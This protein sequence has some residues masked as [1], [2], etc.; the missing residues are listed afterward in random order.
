MTI[1]KLQSYTMFRVSKTQNLKPPKPGGHICI[2]CSQCETLWAGGHARVLVPVLPSRLG[3]M[4][5]GA[6]DGAAAAGA[7]ARSSPPTCPPCAPDDC[8]PDDGGFVLRAARLWDGLSDACVSDFEFGLCV[9]VRGGRIVW[10]G[11]TDRLPDDQY[12]LPRFVRRSRRHH[13]AGHNARLINLQCPRAH[14]V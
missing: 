6:A 1:S 7:D 12:S 10:T 8:V 2:V 3:P 13:H 14:G 4:A 5:D 11:C 9:A